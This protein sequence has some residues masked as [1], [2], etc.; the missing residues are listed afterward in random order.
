MTIVRDQNGEGH[1]ILTVKSSRGDFILDNM[2]QDI[3]LWDTTGY[4]FYKR[5]SQ[6]N[7]NTWVAIVDQSPRVSSLR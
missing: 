7:P 1:T 3:R 6:Q 2:R 4:Y 5:Q